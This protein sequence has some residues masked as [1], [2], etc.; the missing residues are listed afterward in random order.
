MVL[1]VW[2]CLCGVYVVLVW[3]M[4]VGSFLLVVVV[5]VVVLVVGISFFSSLKWCCVYG[6]FLVN[7][8]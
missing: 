7:G 1:L 2:C 4:F 5:L 8:G 6:G 3:L